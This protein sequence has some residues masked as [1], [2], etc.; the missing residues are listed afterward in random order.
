MMRSTLLWLSERKSIFNFVRRNRLARKGASR[1]VAGETVAE[2]V[3]A[4]TELASRGITATLDLLG[5]SVTKQADADQAAAEYVEILRAMHAAGIEVNASVK[6]TQMGF[7]LDEAACEANLRE[8]ARRLGRG[9]T[10]SAPRR[11]DGRH[12]DADGLGP[13]G[14]PRAVPSRRRDPRCPRTARGRAAVV[15]R[16]G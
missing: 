3:A 1:F 8:R 6:L 11:R 5:E 12:G 9:N 15:A 16:G 4:A 14:D 10:G 13:S 2:G 7:D